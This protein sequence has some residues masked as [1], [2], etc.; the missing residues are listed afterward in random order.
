LKKIRGP[1][2]TKW[3]EGA[4]HDLA[5]LDEAISDEIKAWLASL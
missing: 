4:R 3:F 2:T 1:V 5:N